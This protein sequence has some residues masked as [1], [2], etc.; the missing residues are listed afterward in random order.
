MLKKTKHVDVSCE[1]I[2]IENNWHYGSD[3]RH[4]RCVL[5]LRLWMR[6]ENLHH[7][8]LKR[9]SEREGERREKVV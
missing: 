6:V 2:E 5:P 9:H 8:N 1:W 7:G 4:T 3:A